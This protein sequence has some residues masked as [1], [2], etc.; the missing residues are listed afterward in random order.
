MFYFMSWLVYYYV[1]LQPSIKTLIK[2]LFDKKTI[3]LFIILS[4]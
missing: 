1:V 4:I 3:D 2:M